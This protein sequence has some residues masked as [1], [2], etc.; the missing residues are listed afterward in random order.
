VHTHRFYRSDRD[1]TTELIITSYF[2][3]SSNMPAEDTLAFASVNKADPYEGI[4]G[5]WGMS[6][7][8]GEQPIKNSRSH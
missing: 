6:K 3:V 2:W 5:Y 1:F 4:D 7:A 8:E